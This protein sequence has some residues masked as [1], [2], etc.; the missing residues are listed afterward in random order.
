MALMRQWKIALS[1]AI[2]GAIAAPFAFRTYKAQPEVHGFRPVT[3]EQREKITAYLAKFN[4]CVDFETIPMNKLPREAKAK[5]V[6][7]ARSIL[8][9]L[10]L[11]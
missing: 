9:I 10:F 6:T 4:N 1:L 3:A 7:G 8:L 5:M 2:V 11:A